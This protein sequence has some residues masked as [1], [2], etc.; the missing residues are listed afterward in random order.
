VAIRVP[1]QKQEGFEHLQFVPVKIN[2]IELFIG[3][4]QRNLEL[5]KPMKE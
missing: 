3:D 1:D 2:A 5:M 4:H